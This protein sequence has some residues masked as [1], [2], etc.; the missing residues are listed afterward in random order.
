MPKTTRLILAAVLLSP[1]LIGCTLERSERGQ[2]HSH[3]SFKPNISILSARAEAG[4]A[5]VSAC[6]DLP[7]DLD[8]VLGRLPGDVSIAS[9]AEIIPLSYFELLDLKEPTS[10]QLARRCDRLVFDLPDGFE[11]RGAMLV[12]QRLAASLP[13]DPDW[14]QI[15]G[16]LADMQAGIIIE[17]LEDTAGLSFALIEKPSNMTDLQAHNVVVGIAEPV[18]IGPWILPIE[19]SD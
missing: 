12:V 6:F 13:A 15:Q 19:F 9:G 14:T 5:Y 17:P 11:L 8:W 18:E 10:S 7:S 2:A 1:L 16:T 3:E 4:K